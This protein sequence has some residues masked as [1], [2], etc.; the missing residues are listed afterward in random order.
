MCLPTPDIICVTQR[1]EEFLSDRES[2]TNI[3]RRR[4]AAENSFGESWELM[5]YLA[6]NGAPQRPANLLRLRPSSLNTTA[7]TSRDGRMV[8]RATCHHLLH[9]RQGRSGSTNSS[10]EANETN[11][12]HFNSTIFNLQTRFLHTLLLHYPCFFPPHL[13]WPPLFTCSGPSGLHFT[14]LLGQVC[15]LTYLWFS[16]QCYTVLYQGIKH[17]CQVVGCTWFLYKC[18]HEMA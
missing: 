2:C 5:P 6:H 12:Q 8:A 3:V 18:F 7:E 11:R 13:E 10:M 9:Q 4:R 16:N 14:T 15:I 17:C 1:T